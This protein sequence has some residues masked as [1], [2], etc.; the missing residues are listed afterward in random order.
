M[1]TRIKLFAILTSILVLGGCGTV[2]T[3]GKIATLPVTL[4]VKGVMKTGQLAGRGVY[5]TGKGAYYT[6]K[7]LYRV[8]KVPVDITNAALDTSVKFL[9]VTTQVVDLTGKVVQVSRTMQRGEVDA[10]INQAKGA[11]NILGIFV[12]VAHA[13]TGS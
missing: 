13:V 6:G 9:T 2:K 12:D 7:G 3:I 10:Y 1:N 4:P 5:A 11:A 8:A